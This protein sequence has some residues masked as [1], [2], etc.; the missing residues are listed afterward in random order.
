M[1][2]EC[3]KELVETRSVSVKVCLAHLLVI[4]LDMDDLL[5]TITDL[6]QEIGVTKIP[7]ITTPHT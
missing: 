2:H 1:C 4:I 6:P 7:P 3:H 5:S